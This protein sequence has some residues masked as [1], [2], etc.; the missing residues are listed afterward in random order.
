MEMEAGRQQKSWPSNVWSQSYT[1][2]QDLRENESNIILVCIRL[3]SMGILG[4]TV[5]EDVASR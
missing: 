4:R 5:S 2:I 1:S 3:C